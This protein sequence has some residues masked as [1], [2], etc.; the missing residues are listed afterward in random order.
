MYSLIWFQLI[1]RAIKYYY[2]QTR[3][4]WK[5]NQRKTDTRNIHFTPKL[6]N[7]VQNK[8]WSIR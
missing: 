1:A 5:I 3:G 7:Q 8:W 4:W 2:I 6:Y